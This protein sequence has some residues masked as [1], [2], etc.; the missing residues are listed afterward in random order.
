MLQLLE[1]I[2]VARYKEVFTS[3]SKWL[4][5]ELLRDRSNLCP[6]HSSSSRICKLVKAFY[7]FLTLKRGAL[8]DRVA[9]LL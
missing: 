1:L 8:I 5:K 7:K 9:S 6:T 4:L 3:T 2:L